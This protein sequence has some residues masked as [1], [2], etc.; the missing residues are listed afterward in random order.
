MLTKS[1]GLIGRLTEMYQPTAPVIYL[2]TA[3]ISRAWVAA[4]QSMPQRPTRVW[5]AG[6]EE[7]IAAFT[8]IEH[9]DLGLQAFGLSYTA[10]EPNLN[11]AYRPLR[12][13]MIAAIPELSRVAFSQ[14]VFA[15]RDV[16]RDLAERTTLT[17][18]SLLY[19]D[20]AIYL[21]EIMSIRF[22]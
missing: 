11:D 7:M 2:H 6:I 19:N 3:E 13:A 15:I 22:A 17:P 18:Y 5:C 8:E 1:E 20:L 21:D 10:E 9:G 4:I 12:E 16:L 14:E